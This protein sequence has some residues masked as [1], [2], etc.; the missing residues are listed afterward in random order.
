MSAYIFTIFTHKIKSISRQSDLARARVK[1]CQIISSA[2]LR[3]STP[4]GNGMRSSMAPTKPGTAK[5][6]L[7]VSDRFFNQNTPFGDLVNL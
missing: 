5:V 6:A 4:A 3:S 7:F 1:W 2:S